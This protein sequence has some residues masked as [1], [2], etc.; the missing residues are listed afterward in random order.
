MFG[1][2]A[3][4]FAS[5]LAATWATPNP[6]PAAIKVR[7]DSPDLAAVTAVDPS[8]FT[9]YHTGGLLRHD[10]NQLV[11]RACAKGAIYTT[12]DNDNG[13]AGV[14]I[15]N[16]ATD[17]RGFYIYANSCD[18]I[19]YKYIWIPG[20]ATKFVSLYSRFEG[21]ITR[22]TDALNLAGVPQL[23]GTWFEFNW[24][25]QGVI[26]GDVS[27]I[28][29]C[30]GAVLMWSTDGSGAWKGFLQD[31]LAG[32]PGNAFAS[33]PDG[34]RVLGPTEGPTANAAAKNYELSAV[35]AGNA[36]IDD[37]HGNPVINSQNGRFKVWFDPGRI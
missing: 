27:L 26:W 8:T 4:V 21:R 31:V 13:G 30:D 18:S 2:T 14:L 32:A 5:L 11:R 20:G 37:S 15:T 24:D 29:G 10:D 25:A 36:Y 12:G 7:A 17:Y 35:G 33:K 22:G 9:S 28:R 16:G 3:F 19:P 6:S 1:S 34:T 23:L